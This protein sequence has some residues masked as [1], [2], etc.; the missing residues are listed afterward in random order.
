MGTAHQGYG[1]TRRGLLAA[2]ATGG[3]AAL[4]GCQVDTGSGD[5]G[6]GGGGG[7]DAKDIQ[8]PDYGTELTTE[9]ATLRW[10]DSGDLKALFNGPVMD[11]F[12]EKH[13]NIKT[14]YD[15]G[16]WALV[17]KVVPLGIRNGNAP[18]VFAKP[19]GMPY[20]TMVTEGWIRPLDDI[21]PDFAAWKDKFP[22]TAFIPGLHTFKGKTYSWPQS[23]NRRLSHMCIWDK[24]NLAE[25]GYDDPGE[26]QTWDDFHTALSKVVKNGHAGLMV[27]LEAMN[28]LVNGFAASIGWMGVGGMDYRTGEFVW[29]APEVLEA[30]EFV[31]KLEKDK[32]IVPGFL[33]LKQ[34]DARAQMPAGDSAVVI[35]GPWDIPRWKKNSPDWEYVMEQLP[36]RDGLDYILPKQLHGV[37]GSYVYKDT[38]LANAVGQLVAYMGSPEGQKKMVVLSQGNLTSVQDGVTEEAERTG[39]LDPNA[40]RAAN[41]A[42][43]LLRS[44]PDVA[45]RNPDVSKVD[46]VHEQVTPNWRSIWQ[47][48]FS[49]EI[50][51]VE[52]TVKDF[53]RKEDEALD[54]AIKVAAEQEDSSIVRDDYKFGNW[55]PEEDYTLEDY[56]ELPRYKGGE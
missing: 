37:N 38:K 22:K 14:K 44:A 47:G 25:A 24:K 40:L 26:I 43:K 20:A 6:G 28:G 32:L 16:G 17:N 3:I 49:G 56:Q 18:D 39:L 4:A 30:F 19:Q 35:S 55:V 13:P 50:T 1:F 15:G 2:A 53:N 7:G 34:A 11:A 33:T 31:R 29:D 41:L 45:I 48:V 46:I 54:K 9:D 52:K 36:G 23:S 42:K 51:D 21:I 12:T 10:V 27:G 5:G 8:F